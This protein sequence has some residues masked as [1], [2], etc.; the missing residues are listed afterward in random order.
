MA[1][2]RIISQSK[3]LYV[4]PTGLLATKYGYAADTGALAPQQLHKVDTFSFDVD[5]AGGR[6]DIREFGQLARV[7]TVRVGE[8]TPTVSFGYYL[9]DGSNEHNL[10][11]NTAGFAASTASSQ[12]ISGILTENTFKNEKNLYLLTVA[13]GVDAFDSTAYTAAA[14][15]GHDV[16]GFG[17]ATL[18]SYSI[19]LAVGEIPRADIEMECG[20]VRFYDSTSSGVSCVN[21]ALVRATAATADTGV[22]VLTAPSTGV[23]S[24]DVLR[25]GD[26]TINFTNNSAGIGGVLLSGIHIQTAAIEVPLSRT[27]IERLGSQLPFAKPIEFPINVTCSINGIVNEFGSGSLQAILTG[28]AGESNNDITITV[29]DR[30]QNGDKLKYVFKNA[31]LDSQNF[32]I[33]LDDNETVDLTF[34]A[35][36]GGANT[37]TAGVFMSGYFQ[38]VGVTGQDNEK[39]HFYATN[40]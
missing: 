36:I 11:L 19:N 14:R 35:Q 6:Q 25:P 7:A 29:K 8:I 33:G 32:S 18:S 40:A 2:T 9:G 17:N 21:P 39:P 37:T 31:V 26:V 27:S 20:N 15:S 30:C 3:A 34:S 24:V 5:L 16:V 23:G 12:L 13:E 4:S 10:G 38:G 22:F 1:R 28:C